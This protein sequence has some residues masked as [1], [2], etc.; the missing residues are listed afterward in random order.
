MVIIWAWAEPNIS[1]I[2]MIEEEWMGTAMLH[3]GLPVERQCKVWFLLFV[4]GSS[5]TCGFRLKRV[6]PVKLDRFDPQ[7]TMATN[8]G[9]DLS[10]E[11]GVVD[12]LRLYCLGCSFFVRWV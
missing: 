12:L 8:C 5:R 10:Y 2:V 6:E 1:L 11:S 3:Q 4:F 9:A 7:V